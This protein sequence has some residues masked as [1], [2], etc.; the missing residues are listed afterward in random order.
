MLNEKTILS[1]PNL[2]LYEKEGFFFAVDPEAPNWI[3][4][5]SKGAKILRYL[6]GHTPLGKVIRKYA[7]EEGVE[8]S[9]AWLDVDTFIK[10]AMRCKFV[11]KDTYASAQYLGRDAYLKPEKLMELWLHPNNS[12]NLTCAHCLVE[13]HP[14]AIHGLPTEFFK[15]VIDEAYELGVRRFYITGG[16]PFVRGDIF[17]FIKQITEE[18]NSELII[19]TNATLLRGSRLERLKNL[20]RRDLI[21][22]QISLD[23]SNPEI[24]DPIR[25][26]GTFKPIIQGIRNAVE[27]GFNPTVTTVLAENNLDDLPSIVELIKELRVRNLHLLWPHRRGRAL[28]FFPKCRANNRCSSTS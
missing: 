10:D 21:M 23:G 17:D 13:S 27:V 26:E 22:L 20:P 28:E 5:D 19:L 14:Y 7:R 8:V 15:K 9:K 18:K 3:V 6:D 24:N 25:G 2:S 4:T 1:T 11:S 12:C 16:E